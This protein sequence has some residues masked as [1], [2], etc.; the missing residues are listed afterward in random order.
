MIRLWATWAGKFINGKWDDS[1]TLSIFQI[2]SSTDI[3]KRIYL[4]A[5]TDDD[6]RGRVAY[7]VLA[8]LIQMCR[9]RRRRR[10]VCSI[11]RFSSWH[12]PLP[13]KYILVGRHKICNNNTL[14]A[15][16]IEFISSRQF[17][18]TEHTTLITHAR[19]HDPYT[20]SI[21]DDE[22]IKHKLLRRRREIPLN[23]L[24]CDMWNSVPWLE[25]IIVYFTYGVCAVP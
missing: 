11:A 25:L 17:L 2:H 3:I 1:D 10:Y 7:S 19:L 8:S 13:F 12:C 4:L 16:S 5:R 24:R 9:R 23:F 15:H 21:T 18:I 20:T 14:G 6:E 22:C